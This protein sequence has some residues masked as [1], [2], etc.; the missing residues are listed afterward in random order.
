M[1]CLYVANMKK[2]KKRLVKLMER[3]RSDD[4]SGQFHWVDSVLVKALQEGHW[5]LISNANFCRYVRMCI[6]VYIDHVRLV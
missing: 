3:I 2:Y 4:S 5:L 6:Y 1:L